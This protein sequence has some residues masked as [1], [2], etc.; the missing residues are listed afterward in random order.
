MVVVDTS[1]WI[2]VIRGRLSL[3]TSLAADE[4]LAI[5]P[6]IF[7][8]LLAGVRSEIDYRRLRERLLQLPMLDAPMPAETF[9]SA[10]QIYRAGR[11]RGQTIRSTSDC[12][13]AATALRHAA[14]V[15]HRDRDFETIASWTPLR[16]RAAS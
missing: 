13:I 3:E 15:L 16:V 4:E 10:A 9:E 5:T 7:G 11:M 12:L 1:V 14:L 8:E 2:E 6:V